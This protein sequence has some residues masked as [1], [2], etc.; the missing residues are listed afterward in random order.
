VG[1]GARTSLLSHPG[2]VAQAA[3]PPE[4]PAAPREPAR[5]VGAASSKWFS[6]PRAQGGNLGTNGLPGRPAEQPGFGARYPAAADPVYGD[7]T[8][9]GLPLRV[10][11]ANLIP[12]SIDN[13]RQAGSTR[14][15]FQ[16]AQPP[17]QSWQERTP[18]IA[19]S[20]MSGFQRG[21]RRGKSQTPRAGEGTDR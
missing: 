13:T 8:S 5:S 1:A 17:A 2:P 7:Q 18:E 21:V 10:P 16:G 6:D 11:L 12:G 20:R 19:R 3:L 15:A 9:S 14:Q 4:V